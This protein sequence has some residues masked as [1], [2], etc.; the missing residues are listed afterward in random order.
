MY[1]V[2]DS[3]TVA[4]VKIKNGVKLRQHGHKVLVTTQNDATVTVFLSAQYVES[5]NR[6]AY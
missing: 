4:D 1:A 3:K 5:Q 6:F 2:M